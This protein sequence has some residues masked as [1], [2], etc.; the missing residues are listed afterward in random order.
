MLGAALASKLSAA[1]LV[2]VTVTAVL[3]CLVPRRGWKRAAA[4][5]AVVDTGGA[6]V[7]AGVAHA[8][9]VRVVLV[10]VGL[11]RAVVAQ[12]G[13]AVAVV[14]VVAG[15]AEAVAVGIVLCGVSG[16]RA[17]VAASWNDVV[18]VL[19][20]SVCQVPDCVRHWTS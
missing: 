8:V 20:I 19:L 6:V 18:V 10:G 4:A 11:E 2:P 17:V 3:V 7:L 1:V 5:L 15:V 9:A 14:V 12:V 16:E 13:H